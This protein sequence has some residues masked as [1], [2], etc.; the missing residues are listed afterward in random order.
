MDR[1]CAADVLDLRRDSGWIRFEVRLRQEDDRL[2][3][4]LQRQGDVTLEDEPVEFLAECRG[5]EDDVHV[6]RD[7]LL[8]GGSRAGIRGRT[9][10]ECRS[11]R[12]NCLD[13]VGVDCDPVADDRKLRGRCVATKAR[14][15][16]RADITLR[17][18]HVVCA[19]M[20]HGDASRGEPLGPVRGEGIV[21]AFVPAERRKIRHRHIVPGPA[22]LR[23]RNRI[24]TGKRRIGS[25]TSRGSAG[26]L[27]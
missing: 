25:G 24:Y 21:P 17:C 6:R 18:E 3:A 14:R 11:A 10:H 16:L 2:R 26:G 5:H 19:P 22:G 13:D 27:P 7:D 1:D 8:A 4:A 15:E 12:E 20:L 23:G 9:A